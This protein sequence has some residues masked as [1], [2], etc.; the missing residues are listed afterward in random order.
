MND[1]EICINN[2]KFYA[3]MKDINLGTLETSAGV[4]VGYFSRYA[5][6]GW[7]KMPVSVLYKVSEVL[8]V[9]V[10][11]L[12]ETRETKDFAAE[13]IRMGKCTGTGV[14]FTGTEYK[15]FIMCGDNKLTIDTHSNIVAALIQL[16]NLFT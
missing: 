12:L 6:R 1:M 5:K 2:I 4:S 8:G 9:D 13:I 3:K 11:S 15:C 16:T 10:N 7:K 14:D